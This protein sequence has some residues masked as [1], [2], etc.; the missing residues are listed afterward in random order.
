MR[1]LISGYYGFGNVGDEAILASLVT[2]LHERHP[3]A[4][5]C[6]LSAQPEVTARELGVEAAQR[7][8]W[9]VIWRELKRADLLIQGGG[10][11]LQDTTSAI[12]P[13]YYLG[14]LRL[15]RLAGTPYAIFAQGL[16][17]L[18][19]PMLR[20]LARRNLSRAASITLRDEASA[21]FLLKK[22]R[23]PY[24]APVAPDPAL[25]LPPA[26]LDAAEEGLC[27]A[28][29][30]P[31]CPRIG[32][33]LREWPDLAPVEAA[34][35]ELIARAAE[36]WGA[37]CLLIPF[38]READMAQCVRLSSGPRAS[39]WDKPLL[40][41]ELVALTARLDMV[42]AMRLHA[43]IF[44]VSQTVPMVGLS[45][46][47]KVAAFC[48]QAGQPCLELSDVTPDGLWHWASE[49]FDPHCLRTEL[50]SMAAAELSARAQAHLTALDEV[51]GRL[52]RGTG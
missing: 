45:Y 17:P 37:R 48:K 16:G 39:V 26:S 51:I 13:L 40:P 9:G 50:L 41:Q 2:H 22:L 6:V 21:G 18:R 27:D 30:G 20:R 4:Q 25:C 5:V 12:S 47:P 52:S 24:E 14:V 8:S 32:I 44:A 46:D 31:D 11:L 43:L 38:Q 33:V 42:V 15:A 29:L 28:G 36:E 1:I 19:R 34:V 35:S 7:W 49:A 10:G 23:V 3:E